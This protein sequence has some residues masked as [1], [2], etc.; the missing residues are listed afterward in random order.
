MDTITS[1]QNEW[2]IQARKLKQKKHRDAEGLFLAE[3]LRLCEEAAKSSRVSE[4]YYHESLAD[5]ERGADLLKALAGSAGR[6]A[7]VSAKVMDALSE[8]E[9]PQ[10]I[11]CVC[12]MNRASLRAFRP[13]DGIMLAVDGIRD[14]G[15][16]GTIIRTMWACGA[17]GLICLSGTTDPYNGKCVRASMGGVF[18]LP[19]FCDIDWAE[20]YRWVLETGYKAIGADAGKGL[21]YGAYQWPKRSLIC[22]GGEAAGITSIP[23]DA[24]EEHV[25][26]PL[27]HGAESLNAGVATGILLY[28]AR[29]ATQ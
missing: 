18:N 20:A 21:E 7:R 13:G 23:E 29:H 19:V 5:T 4:V 17:K 6:F 16:L 11:V 9:S 14:P 27:E 25:F 12:G 22:V 28:A 1:A 26:I 3:G 2:I 24:I 8:T 10:G 15:N